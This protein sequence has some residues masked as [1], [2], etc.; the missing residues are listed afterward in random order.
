[1]IDIDG[2]SREELLGLNHRIIE[3]LKF[4]DSAQAQV[5]M[6][7]FHLGAPVSFETQEGRQQG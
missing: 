4:L 5:D 2:L 6:M 7:S 1:M 3:R